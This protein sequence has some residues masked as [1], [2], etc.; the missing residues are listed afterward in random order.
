MS[1][2][3]KIIRITKGKRKGLHLDWNRR[4]K[5]CLPTNDAKSKYSPIPHPLLRLSRLALPPGSSPEIIEA[6]VES[7]SSSIALNT[8]SGY[9]TATRQYFA[10]KKALGRAFSIPPSE[11][12]LMFLTTYLIKQNLSVPTVRSYLAGIRYCLLCLGVAIPPRLP[13]LA[14]ELLIG[15]HN[16]ERS[17]KKLEENQT[18]H[19]ISIDM[20]KLLGHGIATHHTWSDFEKSLRLDHLINP[21]AQQFS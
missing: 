4:K 19:A 5:K 9:A 14:E 12:D 3:T 2:P 7:F 16:Q 13:P 15:K 21:K 1:G 18:K 10:A 20:P 8:Q 17:P 11:S 6:A